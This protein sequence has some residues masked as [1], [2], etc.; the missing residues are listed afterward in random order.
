MRKAVCCLIFLGG[1]VNPSAQ[2]EKATFEAIAPEYS[3][4][5]QADP[6]LSAEAKS[7][8]LDTVETWRRR[9]EVAK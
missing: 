9:V 5:V 3:A 6:N 4:Y 2:A 1:C 7:I 8:R